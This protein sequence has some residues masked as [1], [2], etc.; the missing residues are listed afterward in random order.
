MKLIDIKINNFM[1]F[2]GEQYV[3]FPQDSQRNVLLLYGENGSGKTSFL[4]A[5]RWGF[6]GK[7]Y[8]RHKAVISLDRLLNKEAS[9]EGGWD[10]FVEIKF[11][12]EGNKFYLLRHAQKK[13]NINI[14]NNDS[15]YEIN[16]ILKK[17]DHIFTAD[18][19]NSE[20][21]NI[22]PEKVSRFFLFDGELL[23]EYESL[24]DEKN[25]SAEQI[26]SAIEQVLGVPALINGRIECETLYKQYTKD[27]NKELQN[28]KGFE[29][30]AQTQFM[31][32]AKL[33]SKTNDI[34]NQKEK[35]KSIRAD[36][37]I[38]NDEI[39]DLNKLY[40]EGQ[41]IQHLKDDKKLKENNQNVFREELLKEASTAWKELL[42]PKLTTLEKSL[43]SNFEDKVS[44]ISKYYILK[45]QL[46]T[47]EEIH[48]TS[49][50]PICHSSVANLRE[51]DSEINK[52]KGQ[53]N[54]LPYDIEEFSKIGQQL[55]AI[56]SLLK[57]EG[58]D[59]LRS[60]SEKITE[61]EIALVRIE[62]KLEDLYEKSK[63]VNPDEVKR[64][65]SQYDNLTHQEGA[66]E[67]D[68]KE[69][70]SAINSFRLQLGELDRKIRS[71][72]DSSNRS[73]AER[74]AE[75]FSA[76]RNTFSDSIALLRE[77]LK[78]EV[79]KNATTAFKAIILEKDY[80]R[81]RINNNYGLS[82]ADSSGALVDLR[83]AGQEE[84][85]ALSLIDGLSH[86]GRSPGPVV[87]DTPF[88]RM[89]PGHRKTTPEYSSKSANQLALLVHEGEIERQED[90]LPIANK[91]G[92]QYEII[93]VN[94]KYSRI[95]IYY[96]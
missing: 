50:C 26:K 89:D 91:I 8:T 39:D 51:C 31:L 19:I 87:M 64:K 32:T 4:N 20:I 3:Q 28:K 29:I 55:S 44:Q 5:I 94:S 68:I 71:N 58:R 69:T 56:R 22:S 74:K 77:Q 49:K 46:S 18:K 35:L 14:P 62:Q 34:N 13:S 86:T 85:V 47:L 27:S 21:N 95:D 41:E 63:G 84:I 12:H 17:D 72:T 65:K 16:L 33:E 11:E 78:K 82:I 81:L 70:D 1:R 37:N 24:L 25:S 90:L 80:Q 42:K 54:N 38:I 36:K 45:N 2:K 73:K 76:L 48:I 23:Q 92:Y 66:L 53:L 93:K 57:S 7:V 52:V 96:D 61:N 59:K 40:K 79:E 6:Y 60:I 67:R 10:F 30:D 43:L 88:G 9:F 83:S 15:D 75:I